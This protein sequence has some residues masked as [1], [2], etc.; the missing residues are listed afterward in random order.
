LR[1]PEAEII[2]S[3]I[4]YG[5]RMVVFKFPTFPSSPT[6]SELAKH[7]VLTKTVCTRI[8]LVCRFLSTSMEP[9]SLDTGN[10]LAA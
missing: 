4:N 8:A 6:H 7:E 9:Q 1:Y 2:E 3:V 5:A 10:K